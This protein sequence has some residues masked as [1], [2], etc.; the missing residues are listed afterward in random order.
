[1]TAHDS[2][3]IMGFR[4]D[5]RLPKGSHSA[6][7]AVGNAVC[8]HM[9]KAIVQAAVSIY[10]GEPMPKTTSPSPLPTPTPPSPNTPIDTHKRLD[11]IET[12][13]GLN[14]ADPSKKARVE[15][16]EAQ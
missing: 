13:C 12:L 7:R 11:T 15:V 10:K 6:Q 8:V 9:S 5:W 4:L 16:S 2:A 1:M 3:I 14:D